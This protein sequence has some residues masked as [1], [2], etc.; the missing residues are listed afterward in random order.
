M[1]SAIDQNHVIGLNN[2]LPWHLPE[3]LAYFKKT[4]NDHT[5]VMGRKTYESIGK[6]LPNRRNIIISTSLT[7]EDVITS[8]NQ[9]FSL[10]LKGKV[11]IIG[12]AQIY[13]HF[14]P[15]AHYLY[16][17]HLDISVHGDSFFPVLD[18]QQWEMIENIE[19]LP[20]PQH[21]FKRNY[22][23]YKRLKGESTK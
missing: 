7:G 14:L 10:G 17:T 12:G 9:L 21:N 1:I 2:Q 19:H 22:C 16:L 18:L 8:P 6:K 11:F 20:C 15:Y 3:D 13:Q 5:V 23:V 4:T